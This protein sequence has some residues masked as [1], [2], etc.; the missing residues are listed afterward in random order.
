MAAAA[1]AG[2]AGAAMSPA[3]VAAASDA[4]VRLVAPAQWQGL[5]PGVFSRG[6]VVRPLVVDGGALVVTPPPARAHPGI[7]R[8]TAATDVRASTTAT[9]GTVDPA[10][11]ALGVVRFAPGLG[12]PGRAGSTRLAWVGVVG[13]ELGASCPAERGGTG[14]TAV[15]RPAFHVVVVSADGSGAL[16]Y[17]SAGTSVCGGPVRPPSLTGA[18]RIVSVPWTPVGTSELAGTPTRYVWRISYGVP[19]C[20]G[21]FDSPGIF[22][23]APGSPALYVEVR[24]PLIDPRNCTTEQ[25]STTDFGPEFVPVAQAGHAPLGTHQF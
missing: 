25:E 8:T 7:D 2:V 10:G 5:P 22:F 12:A 9:P 4:P 21:V 23:T 3:G 20:G 11:T 16:E 13:P 18:A 14:R 24:L 17:T 1:L 6:R 15:Y 19:S